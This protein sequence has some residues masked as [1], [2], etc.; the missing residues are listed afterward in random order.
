MPP[1]L[2]QIQLL[3]FDLDGTLI[4]SVPDLADAVDQMLIELDRPRAGQDKVRNWVGQGA[5]VLVKRAL[6][7]GLK[8]DQI[9][10]TSELFMRAYATFLTAYDANKGAKTRCYAGIFELLNAAKKAQIPMALITNKPYRFVP[11]ILQSLKLDHYFNLVLGGD[12]LAEK[13][14][15]PLPLLYAAEQL[16]V[17]PKNCVMI[18][19][20]ITDISAGQQAGF[21]TVAVRYGYDHGVPVDQCGAD[22]VVDSLA[23]LV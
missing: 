22:V 19:D 21:K 16:Q 13:K 15:S 2:S 3:A 12:S 6:A 10:E 20:S 7:D 18:G 4:D 23:E 11:E 1:L 17:D 9:D 8:I 5:I 14:P